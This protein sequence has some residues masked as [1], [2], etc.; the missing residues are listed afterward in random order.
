MNWVAIAG[1]F[2][3]WATSIGLI[4][5]AANLLQ[6]D[7]ALRQSAIGW[8]RQTL[9]A[10]SP[11]D[12]TGATNRA[13]LKLFDR[14]YGGSGG[15]VERMTWIGLISSLLV[16][17]VLRRLL[18]L[19]GA[20]ITLDTTTLL[21]IAIGL[22]FLLSILSVRYLEQTG[23]SAIVSATIIGVVSVIGF[24][25]G[26]V[27]VSVIGR[28]HLP[29]HPRKAL[30]SSLIFLGVVSLIRFGDA[31]S[32]F[33]AATVS[34]SSLTLLAFVALNLFADAISLLET[35]WVLQR[36]ADA[37][38]IKLLGLLVLDLILSA[39]IFL[40]LP[41]VLWE[42][43]AFAEAILF[44]GDRAWLGILFWSTF[45]TSVLFYLFVIS[46]LVV[47]FLARTVGPLNK[48]FADP[49][50]LALVMCAVVT[51]LF[52]AGSIVAIAVNKLPG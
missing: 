46:T 9:T 13:F 11:N 6:K 35:R 41:L 3:A 43:P 2:A 15:L 5:G 1:L 28:R 32:F 14:I 47:R 17:L 7:G 23:D 18:L 24:I 45:A 51:V 42:I 10:S 48:L 50:V 37:G 4:Y 12:W 40:F 25:M 16:W 52:I 26:F 44:H 27:S 38:V 20:E 39:A 33:Q 29:I 31:V 30:A 19:P 8:I 49:I 22:A 21:L 34:W 36:G